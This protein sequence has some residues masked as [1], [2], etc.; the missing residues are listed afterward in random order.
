MFYGDGT[1]TK[2]TI[3]CV[4]YVNKNEIKLVAAARKNVTV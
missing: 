2:A 1:S 4:R 3:I